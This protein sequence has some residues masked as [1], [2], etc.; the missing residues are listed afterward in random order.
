LNIFFTKDDLSSVAG[1]IYDADTNTTEDVHNQL[2]NSYTCLQL[3]NPAYDKADGTQYTVGNSYF[4]LLQYPCSVTV[5]ASDTT[6]ANNGIYINGSIQQ[7]QEYQ[8]YPYNESLTFAVRNLAG[9]VKIT[10]GHYND[11]DTSVTIGSNN[12]TIPAEKMLDDLFVSVAER[13]L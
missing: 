8:Y 10:K 5:Y 11:I 12:V 13:T 6:S 2:I 9:Q 1:T 3:H 4:G 7:R